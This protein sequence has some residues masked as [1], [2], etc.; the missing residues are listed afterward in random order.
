M[1]IVSA[2]FAPDAPVPTGTPVAA[3]GAADMGD[4]G[5]FSSKVASI[6]DAG[7]GNTSVERGA[8]GRFTISRTPSVAV[9]QAIDDESH[10]VAFEP[11]LES[12]TQ[13]TQ[14][15]SKSGI[16]SSASD[17]TTI[18]VEEVLD[19][20]DSAV[21]AFASSFLSA[22]PTPLTALATEVAASELV[23]APANTSATFAIVP[24]AAPEATADEATDVMAVEN[25]PP[26]S[27]FAAEASGKTTTDGPQSEAARSAAGSGA[28]KQSGKP[29]PT[30]RPVIQTATHSA[31]PSGVDISASGAEK[32]AFQAMSSGDATPSAPSPIA[33]AMTAAQIPTALVQ[34][35]VAAASP[36]PAQ[37][38]SADIAAAIGMPDLSADAAAGPAHD[39][40]PQTMPAPPLK[41]LRHEVAH[42]TANAATSTVSIDTADAKA[43]GVQTP[44]LA[45]AGAASPLSAK[46]TATADATAEPTPF[47]VVADAAQ[48]G[49]TAAPADPQGVQQ[50]VA[51]DRDL[52]LSTLSRATVET[53]AQLAAQIARR[54]DNRSTRF[55]MVLT[56]EDLGRVDVSLEIGKD[57]QL[58]A[59]LAFDNPAAAADLK[60]RADELRRQ[61]QDAGFQVA[62]DALD[63]SQRDPSAGNGGAFDRQQQRN[64]LF[65]GGSRLA[66]QADTPIV[67][68]PGAW[69]NHSQTPDRVDVKV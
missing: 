16:A 34:I 15:A 67:P 5:L 1:S 63:F 28:Q 37:I 13:S 55:D 22:Q 43:T 9:T 64:A 7:L 26:S 56:P 68:A 25:A 11:P 54:L 3:S 2:L 30:V 41:P 40:P 8:F 4:A 60:G 49:G 33:Q 29:T 42:Q 6:L 45:D 38:V 17:E 23:A 58:S 27:S 69:I 39:L 21:A 65:A 51:P 14:G 19:H 12:Q 62:G 52:G 53:T 31:E 46:P 35:S 47:P 10:N 50:A 18:A 48:T 44:S 20:D 59:R 57:G 36:K 61:L 32:A 24:P 66:A